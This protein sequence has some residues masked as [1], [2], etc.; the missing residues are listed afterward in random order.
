MSD[1]KIF[2]HQQLREVTK[3]RDVAI[4]ALADKEQEIC[5]LKLAIKMLCKILGELP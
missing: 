1:E 2:D 5:R 4:A 3:Q